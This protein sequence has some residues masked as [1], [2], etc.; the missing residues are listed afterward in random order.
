MYQIVVVLIW[1]QGGDYDCILV[2][3]LFVCFVKGVGFCVYG[4]VVFLYVVVMVGVQQSVVGMEQG[5]VN[6]DVV[7]CEFLLCFVQCYM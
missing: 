3:G 4:W 7:F 6:W 2:I 5:G 1:C